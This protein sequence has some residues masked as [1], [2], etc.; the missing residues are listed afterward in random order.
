MI[1]FLVAFWG[2]LHTV[3][4]SAPA[5][6]R[7]T[8]PGPPIA[9]VGYAAQFD[10]AAFEDLRQIVNAYLGPHDRWID[11]TNE[12]ALFYYWLDRDPS[13]RWVA[14]VS[15]P[16]HRSAAAQP[17]RGATP[18]ATEAD[19]LRRHRHKMYGLPAI[20]G[21]PATVFLYLDSRWILDHYRPLL[22]SHGR[23]I[24]ALPGL[25]PVRAFICSYISNRRRW[26]C[27]SLAR[28]ASGRRPDL[29][30]RTGGAPL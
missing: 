4:E 25:R 17:P 2:P 5:R 9:R 8:A 1:C 30:Q 23:T 6:Y 18:C 22:E 29:P 16:Q 7:P 3:V 14:P 21:V 28:R 11:I 26:G 27:R 13:S 20:S 12:P 10:G 15:T 24:Y 19:R